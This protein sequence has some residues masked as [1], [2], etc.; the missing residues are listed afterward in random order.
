[1]AG[2][3]TDG[4]EDLAGKADYAL[5]YL[6]RALAESGRPGAGEVVD[7]CRAKL[8]QETGWK[9]VVHRIRPMA[10]AYYARDRGFAVELFEQ[11]LAALLGKRSR[12]EQTAILAGLLGQ[13][14]RE[15][16][17]AFAGMLVPRL[18]RLVPKRDEWPPELADLVA[19]TLS[20]LQRYGEA[21]M[22]LEGAI[23]RLE[24][25][26]PDGVPDKEAEKA[27]GDRYF[28]LVCQYA[29][30]GDLT[31]AEAVFERGHAH[32][33]DADRLANL[34]H[35]LGMGYLRLGDGPRATSHFERVVRSYPDTPW[36]KAAAC[37][38][39]QPAA[40]PAPAQTA[41]N[42]GGPD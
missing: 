10:A 14:V 21:A 40:P 39:A 22:E 42:A 24:A 33:K 11:Y 36:A 16:R 17:W 28:L 15:G 38:L 26:V 29:A 5:R 8:A 19:R 13:E 41:P 20:G 35:L 9:S 32:L 27:L 6:S 31:R 18:R 12:K 25:R 30:S 2:A 4:I 37:Q 1:M 34:N 23:R 3:P 7:R